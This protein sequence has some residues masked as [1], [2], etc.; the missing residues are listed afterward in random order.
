MNLDVY[1]RDDLSEAVHL[2]N[3]GKNYESYEFM[4]VQ[5]IRKNGRD[6]ASFTVW[7]PHAREV[8]LVGD[9]NQ[10]HNSN[11]PMKNI[12]GSG[13]WNI[14]ISLYRQYDNYKYRII[15]PDYHEIYKADPYAFH[16]E[17]RP[18]TASKVYDI[19]GFKWSD[20]KYMQKRLKT[21]H[22]SKP[23]SIYE[24]NA[25]SWMRHYNNDYYTFNDLAKVLPNYVKDMGYTHVEFM[26]LT[27]F[28]FDGSW[29][30]QVTGYYSITSRYGTPKDFMNLVNEF[31]KRDIGVILDWVPVH[32]TK[33]AHG[34]S[35]FDGWAVYEKPDPYRANNEGW[36]TL[37]FDF[38]K[39]QVKNFLISSALF[40]L[41]YFHIDGLRVDAVTAMLYLNYGGKNLVNENGGFENY[42]A[43]E[44][45]KELNSV[46][47]LYHSDCLMIAEESTSYPKLTHP[48]ENGGLGFDYKWNMGWMHDIL[49]YFELNPIERQYHHD[50]LTFTIT[51]AFSENFVLPF[52]HDEVVH[53]KKS[54]INKMSGY[55]DDKFRALMSLYAYMYAHPGKKLMFMGDEIGTFEEWNYDKELSWSVLN[56][57]R[58]RQLKDFVKKLNEVYKD[59]K[60]LYDIDDSY[61]GYEWIELTNKNQ[62]IIAFERIDREDNKV[63][64]FFN[65][66][67][68]NVDNYRF[69]V[70]KKGLYKIIL[71]TQH[72]NFGGEIQRNTPLY[73]KEIP[74]NGRNYSVEVDLKPYQ[75]LFI[76]YNKK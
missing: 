14:C 50:K 13:I 71:N 74:H 15:S 62:N 2:Y 44:F 42:E 58:H 7:A 73:S 46:V 52:S 55:Y 64:C 24:L 40:F 6:Y 9:F 67:P 4:G 10:W 65:F 36:G 5:K 59:E 18:N 19:K 43:I 11:L 35:Y 75:A 12:N 25:G 66:S 49:D 21:S 30:Y 37:Y 17:F 72:K 31:H 57:D 29:G 3:E 69:G 47:H 56:Y 26:P 70:D 34:L 32:F 41:K 45:I 54:M 16:S 23:I 28:P 53:L 27:E 51:Y 68:V 38:Y 60:P 61:D 39:N 48:I 22:K 20:K 33:D 8:F 1:Y 63:L 76:K